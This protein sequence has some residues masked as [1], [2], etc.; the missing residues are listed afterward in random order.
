VFFRPLHLGI[1]LAALA[2]VAVAGP[3]FA[4]A[5]PGPANQEVPLPVVT[6]PPTPAPV[7][8]GRP[9]RGKHGGSSSASPTPEPTDSPVPPQFT[10][11]DGIWEIEAQPY[12]KKLA[13]YSH[14]SI[15]QAGGQLTGY[16]E[17]HKHGTKLPLS[18]SF[19]GRLIAISVPLADGST[20]TF[21]G[22]VENFGDMV[23]VIHA[24]PRDDGTP[25]TAEHR[26]KE[27]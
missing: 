9:V 19:D 27:R 2:T 26:K 22:Y 17:P 23:G 8:S 10:T 7:T 25:F 11:L 14:F 18:G 5:P 3:S 24:T 20:T 12:N 16:W 21:S 6:P 4:Q 15:H 13:Q 1:G